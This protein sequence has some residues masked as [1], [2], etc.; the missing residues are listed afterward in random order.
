MQLE[1]LHT[2][3]HAFYYQRLSYVVVAVQAAKEA[4]LVALSPTTPSRLLSAPIVWIRY[5]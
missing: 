4:H 3:C 2:T 1:A 5:K